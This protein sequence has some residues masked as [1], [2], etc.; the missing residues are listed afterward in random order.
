MINDARLSSY[1]R[2]YI[3]IPLGVQYKSCLRSSASS[4]SVIG[5]KFGERNFLGLA[6]LFFIFVFYSTC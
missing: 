2:M 5:K 6:C 1:A 3:C 4:Y